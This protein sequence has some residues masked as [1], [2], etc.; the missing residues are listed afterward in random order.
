MDKLHASSSAL[1]N[2]NGIKALEQPSVTEEEHAHNAS[3]VET[4]HKLGNVLS[5]TLQLKDEIY[6]AGNNLSS[7]DDGSSGLEDENVAGGCEEISCKCLQKCATFP[8]T[9][10][11]EKTSSETESENCLYK[12]SLSLP[13]ASNLVSALKGSREKEGL[14]PRKLSVSWAPDVYDPPPT[15][16][17]HYPKK[18]VQQQYTKSNKKYGKGKQKGKTARGGG[19]GP[20]DKKHYRK[21]GGKSDRCLDSYADTDRVISTKS[22]KSSSVGL[23]DFDD[24]DD[25]PGPESNCGSSFRGKAGKAAMH[26]AYAEAT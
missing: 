13:T 4:L 21:M 23:L 11:A 25:I 3:G 15:S 6:V 16:L 24:D 26:F 1:E 17:S 12:R 8:V 9:V 20:K 22:Y 7:D 5:E 19:S 14:P 18:K 10:G 2:V